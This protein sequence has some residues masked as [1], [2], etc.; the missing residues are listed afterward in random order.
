MKD[1]VNL[2]FDLL[3]LALIDMSKAV[4]MTYKQLNILIFC[5]IEPLAYIVMLWII[6]KQY[7]KIKS[8]KK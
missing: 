4:G 2:I 6:I 7:F 5:V 8:L 3:V 1:F